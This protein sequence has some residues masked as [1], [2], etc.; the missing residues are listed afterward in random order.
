MP[1]R[2]A[3]AE[4]ADA[5]AGVHVRSWQIAYR[6]LVPD[7]TL[8]NLD[9]AERATRWRSIFEQTGQDVFVL[10]EHDRIRG[11]C[12]LQP[13]RDEEHADAPVGEISAIYVDPPH[14]R[15]GL[16]RALCEAAMARAR[17]RGFHDLVLWVLEEN[18]G[19]RSFYE[20][21]GFV[22][23][24]EVSSTRGFGN[25]VE[26]SEVRYLKHLSALRSRP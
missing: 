21:L 18:R 6:G 12:S 24:G 3:T 20:E 1:V 13:S 5:I 17:L 8:D 23:D 14:W 15:R 9:V 11:F 4:D 19:A 2:F 16:G 26:L 10:V 22:R 7:A 25:G